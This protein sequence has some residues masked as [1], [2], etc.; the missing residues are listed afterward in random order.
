MAVPAMAA[1][2]GD[3]GKPDKPRLVC[4]R[5][6]ASQSRL[7][8]KVCRPAD[9]KRNK[10]APAAAAAARPKPAAKIRTDSV[11]AP[12]PAPELTAQP[13]Q[14][15]SAAAKPEKKICKRQ[16]SSVSRLGAGPKICRTAAEWRRQPAQDDSEKLLMH[17]AKGR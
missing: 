4:K 12:A 14:V 1:N 7:G 8:T 13:V 10:A 6:Y 3:S 9:E 17:E 16:E 11:A 2:E 5:D 15:A